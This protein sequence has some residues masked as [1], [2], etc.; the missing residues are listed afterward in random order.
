[1]PALNELTNNPENTAGFNVL[2][3]PE[4]SIQTELGVKISPSENVEYSASA[5]LISL[6]DQIQGYELPATPGRT[7]YRNA[8]SGSRFGL[9]LTLRSKLTSWSHISMNYTYADYRYTSFKVN[10]VDFSG[11][12]Q[13]LIPV[14]KF[15]LS[16]STDIYNWVNFACFYGYNNKMFLDDANLTHS[17]PLL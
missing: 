15:N 3:N 10:N 13:P 6:K 5:Y 1:M 2:L 9:E 7:Y 14:H 11:N 16:I 8:T 4:K 17:V 12:L